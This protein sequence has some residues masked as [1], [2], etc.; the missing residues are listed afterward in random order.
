MTQQAKPLT[1]LRDR[2]GVEGMPV[3]SVCVTTYNHHDFITEALESVLMQE[4]NFP[5]EICLHDDCSTDGTTDIVRFYVERYPN[6]IHPIIQAENQY[7]KGKHALPILF[8]HVRGRY[9]AVLEGDDA[10]MD[11][12]KLMRQVRFLD[13]NPACIIC[14]G[15]A[16]IVDAGGRTINEKKIPIESCR[17]LTQQELIEAR[18]AIPTA[19]VMYRNHPLLRQLPDAINRVLNGDTFL[20]ALLA[21]YGQAGFVDFSPSLYRQHAGGIYSTLHENSRR[22]KRIQ[23]LKAL[24][25][26]IDVQY[27]PWVANAISETYLALVDALRHDR[28]HSLFIQQL[29]AV[30]WF[31][32]RYRREADRYKDLRACGYHL[33]HWIFDPER[34]DVDR[35]VRNTRSRS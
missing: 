32:I 4:T 11:P 6:L 12:V 9:V 13:D 29:M 31:A 24:Y 3:V 1:A 30:G 8:K 20:Y 5:V 28:A 33:R 34:K 7:S 22:Q 10:W 21:Q 14:Y 18:H 16:R 25:R 2:T 26:C 15:N 23:T 19:T 27:R 17:V 35:R